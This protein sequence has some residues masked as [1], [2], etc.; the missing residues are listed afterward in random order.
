MKF[1]DGIFLWIA[2]LIVSVFLL[3]TFWLFRVNPP[4]SDSFASEPNPVWSVGVVQ[5]GYARVEKGK[6]IYFPLNLNQRRNLSVFF[7]TDSRNFKIA[8]KVFTDDAFKRFTEDGDGEPF[9][10]TNPVSRG[11]I[12]RLLEPGRYYVVLD[13][14]NGDATVNLSSLDI[15]VE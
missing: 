2:V 5:S 9:I 10:Q 15:S 8:A 3:F 7:R 13:N 6:Y 12:R 14:R 4:E 11:N 1:H